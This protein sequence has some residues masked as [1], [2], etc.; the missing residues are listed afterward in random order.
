MA[1]ASVEL[2]RELQDSIR[3]CLSQG[4]VLQQHR[5]KLETKPKKF[6]DRVLALTSWRLH[7]F[8]LKIPAKVESSFNV[9]EIRAFNTLSQNQILVET[10]RGMVSMRLPSA[11]SVDQV[12]R[13]VSSALSKVCPGPGN[14]IRRGNADTPEGPRDTSPN[15][16]TSTSTTH[17][18]C[19]GFS[20]TYAALCDYNGLHCRE[21][22]QWDVDTIYHAE[23]NREFNLLDFSHLES[24]DLALMV[25]ALAYNQWFTKLYCKDLRLGSEVLEQVLHTLSKSGSL[26]EL[27][28][29]NAGLKTDF[30]QKLAGVFGENGS[31]VLHALTLSHNPIEDKGFLSLSQQLLCF[32]TGLTKLCLA[33]TAISPRGLQALGQTFGANPAFASSL[34]YLD[35]SKNPGLLSTD[36]ANALYSFLAQPNA[37]VHLDLS[38]TDCAIDLLLGALLHGCCSHLT[39][40]NLARNSCSHRKGRE[41]PPAFKQFFSS[42]YTLS[43]INLSATKLP[44]EALRALL[45]GLSLNS[46]LSDLHLDLSSCELRSA[47]AQ[48]LQEQLGAVTCVG[49]LD[50][51]DNGFDSDLLT[52][53]PALGKNKSLKHLFLGKNFN[54]KAKTLEEILHKLVQLIQ[55]EDCSLQSLSVADS[56]LKLRTSILIN[57]LGSN[58]CLAKVDLSGNGME[59]IGAKML[60]KALQ[61]NSSL[62]TI[63]WDRN[64]TSALGFL[65]IARALESNHTLRFMSFPVSDISQAYRSAPERTEDVWQKIQWCLVRNNHSQTCPQEQAF[66]LQQGL[67]TSSAEQMLQRLCGRVQEEVRALRLC[68]LEPVQ[69]ELLY[70]RDLIKDAKNSRAVIL[71]S[72]VSL[73]QELCPVAMRVAEGH[74][75]MLSNVAER[76]TVPRNFI[77]GALLEQAGQDIQNKLDEVKLSV[78]TYLTNS[79]VDEILQELYH[80][81]KSL[82]RHLTQLRTLSDPAGGPGQGQD[83]SS[84]GRGRNHDHEETTDDELGTNIDT[85]AIKKQKRC[86]KIRPVS[87][88]ISG[89]PQDMESQLGNL[90]IPPGWFS[91]LGGSQPTASGSW[92]GLSELPTHGYKLRHQTQGRPRPPRTTPPGPGRPSVPVPGTRQENGMA[93]RLD[94]GLEDFFSRRVMDESSR[95]MGTEGSE[96]GEGDPTPT[97]TQL[98]RVHGV[99]LPGLGRAKGW[100]FDGKQEGTGPDLEGSTQA[101]QKR[102]SSDDAGPG[103]WKPPPPPQSTKPSFSAMRRAEATWHIAEESAPNHS[104][105]SP[106]PASQD[107]EEERE[108]ALFPERMVPARNAKVRAGKLQDPPVA[109]RPPKPVAVPRGRRPPQETGG[110]EEAET[111]GTAPGVHKPRL[112]LGSQQDQEEPEVQGPPDPGRRTAPL[113]PKR[114]RRAQSCDKLEPDRR[115]PPDPT[116]ADGLMPLLGEGGSRTSHRR[117]GG[118]RGSPKILSLRDS[119]SA[120]KKCENTG[121]GEEC[122]ARH[123]GSPFQEL[124]EF[125]AE[126]SPSPPPLLLHQQARS[127]MSDPEM[128]WV[129]EPPAMTLGASRVE[130]RVSC[131]GLL[132]RDTLTKPHPCVLLKHYSDEQWVEVERTEVLRSCSSPVFSRVLALEYFFEE[133]QPLQFHVFDAEDGATSPSNDTFLGSTECTLGQIVSQTKVTKPL[134]LKNGKTAG[135]STITI[136]AEEVSGTNDYVQLTFRAHKLDNKDLFSKSD[137]FME[138]YKTNG[139]QSDQLVWRT[140]VVKNNLNPSWEPFRLSLHSLCSCDVHRPLKGPLQSV[141]DPAPPLTMPSQFLVYDYDSSGKHDFIGEFTS[142]FQEM[143]EGTAN[144]GQEMQWDCINPKYRD[145]KKN[146][147]SSGTVVL[148]QCTVE[149]VHTFLDYIMGGCQI[150]FTVAIDFTASNGD[151]RSSQSLHCLSPRQPNHYLQALRAVGGICQDYD[152]DKRFP[153]FGFG[154]RIPP[155]FEVSHDFAINFDPENPEC[156]EISG[157]IASYRRCLP[158]I[159][160]YGPTNVAPIINRVAEPAQR[161]QSTGQ[162]TKYSVLLVLTDG[163]VSDMAETRTAIV[164]AS[165][166]PMSIIIV[167]VG[168]AD[169]SDMRLLDGDDGTLRCPRGVPA[170]RD[171]VQFVPFRDFKDAAPSA[172]AKCV[173]AE[174]PRQV[175]EYYASQGIS[176]GAPRA[177]TTPS[178]SP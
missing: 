152:S 97:T 139:D 92:E 5:V 46:H 1:K 50:L 54:V 22:V 28:L 169:F 38:G 161:E 7:L 24:R 34:R 75:K 148:A 44:L 143:Q 67:V 37:L 25:A 177:A 170:A 85:M 163:V 96:P 101:W 155:N 10:E 175:V 128:G 17:S 173:L 47:G 168:N 112:R 56:R 3:R 52:L 23:D 27:V 87:A 138:I 116:G 79:I 18:V 63:L 132:D 42:T 19:G 89:S 171:I 151:P 51:S 58:T 122:R 93:T 64:N 178:P 33:K 12:T 108:G 29:D 136:V 131:H 43:H 72:M 77:R 71:E 26:E 81:H 53:V 118:G 121:E 145:K 16:E 157:V 49:S 61:I 30:V 176:P 8:P 167:G 20:E 40:L 11:E 111:G 73:T 45:Q 9:L 4:A 172:L 78:V 84:R 105:Q 123:S 35:L 135:K 133:K 59:D 36:E 126:S 166:L 103:A 127:D 95:K 164:R 141:P 70:A 147:K 48:A 104:C 160:L 14:L 2:T 100:S 124:E 41:A 137:P 94:E 39:Y 158:Q 68:P 113:K 15:S 62:R 83:L 74:N 91:G 154:A 109:P 107:G 106:S 125:S 65:D 57:A 102:R 149:K 82:A 86:R 31:C 6:E 153:A 162:A 129:P 76:V 13:H 156:E 114:T 90:G 117:H 98:P 134:L 66:R 115:R 174:V 146:Y 21:E 159:Q 150:S 69:D 130:L 142:T 140:E 55:E 32:P 99:A 60:S 144:P 110:R 80:S 119:A 165:R 120:A 88:F